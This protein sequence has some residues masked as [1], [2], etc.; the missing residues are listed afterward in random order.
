MKSHLTI[1]VALIV[2]AAPHTAGQVTP[3]RLATSATAEGNWLM[4]SGTYAGHRFSPLDQ[5]TTDNV[6]R[7]KAMWVYQT[8]RWRLAGGPRLLSPTG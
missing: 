3:A 1:V 4:Y 6:G 5:V 7:L 2:G 8:S